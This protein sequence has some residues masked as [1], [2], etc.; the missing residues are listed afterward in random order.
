VKGLAPGK[1]KEFLWATVKPGCELYPDE[2]ADKTP[3]TRVWFL[4]EEGAYVRP[5]VDG[6]GLYYITFQSKWD[7][8]PGLDPQ[9]QFGELLLT[10]HARSG[11]LKEFAQG[12]FNPASTA[13]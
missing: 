10:P 3:R 9:I 13:C 12:F 6:F 4:R 7:N 2:S 1:G 11:T 5:V 8:T